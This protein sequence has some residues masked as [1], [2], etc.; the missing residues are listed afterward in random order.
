MEHG[1]QLSPSLYNDLANQW[2]KINFEDNRGMRFVGWGK[3]L[4][5]YPGY[6]LLFSDQTVKMIQKRVMEI[7]QQ[8]KVVD[9]PVIVGKEV[10][11]NTMSDVSEMA[12]ANVGDMY[13]MFNI[14]QEHPRCDPKTIIKRTI[15][16]ISNYIIN[17]YSIINA[18]K[19]LSVWTTVL[20]GFN[21]HGLRS[22]PP[23]KLKERRTR[24]M[25]FNMN[26]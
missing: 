5:T 1:K 22:H 2:P 12:P 15:N 18:N 19:K 6:S 4:E 7:I 24:P 3:T 25:M 21:K 16:I 14:P 23:I 13:T 11:Y 8:S 20:G 9:R 26:Y 10:I 17:E